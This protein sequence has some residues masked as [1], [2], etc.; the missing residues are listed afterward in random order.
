M[1]E[2]RENERL[3]FDPKQ[4]QLQLEMAVCQRDELRKEVDRLTK[5]LSSIESEHERFLEH[6][7]VVQSQNSNL[8]NL[9]VATSRLHGSLKR[10]EVLDVIEEIVVNLIGSAELAILEVDSNTRQIRVQRARGVNPVP[11]ESIVLGEGKL[12]RA[13]ASGRE[14]ICSEQ[15]SV[16]ASEELKPGEA[17]LTAC[18]PLQV[19]GSVTGAIA[20][21]R[22]LD[23]KPGLEPLDLE[24]LELLGELAGVA[25]YAAA[26]AEGGVVM[27]VEQRR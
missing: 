15:S 8:E 5:A 23:Q 19:C 13:L 18:V 11:L 21:Y 17:N 2:E 1:A 24:L 6:H 14:F 16:A 9:Y 25:L 12:G 27:N 7:A 10:E 3:E 26:L 20:I 4:L 22:L